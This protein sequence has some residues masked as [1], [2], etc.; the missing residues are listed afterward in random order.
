MILHPLLRLGGKL[1]FVEDAENIFEKMMKKWKK[2]PPISYNALLKVYADNKLASKGKDLAKRMSDDGCWIGPLTWDALV[3]LFAEAGEVEKF[4]CVLQIEAA[5][6]ASGN[7][8]LY[9][10][11]ITLLDKYAEVSNVHHAE[12]IFHKLREAKYPSRVNLYKLLAKAYKNAKTPAYGLRRGCK[13]IM[14]TL[15]RSFWLK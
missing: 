13:L 11:Y 9:S 4:D 8:P 7:R 10:S 5:A 14:C 2:I 6:W 12:K 1:G 15:I 3:K